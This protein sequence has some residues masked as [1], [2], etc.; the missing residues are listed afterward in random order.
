M[1]KRKTNN[2]ILLEQF[3]QFVFVDRCLLFSLFFRHCVVCPPLIY[4]SDLVS[5]NS[6]F[7]IGRFPETIFNVIMES[8]IHLEYNKGICDLLNRN[9]NETLTNVLVI[10]VII[11]FTHCST[12]CQNLR[13]ILIS[14]YG[15]SI[16]QMS[17]LG[18][19]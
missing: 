13:N 9:C 3:Q 16:F 17:D 4:G 18:R 7:K 14:L 5:S 19:M 12:I 1:K 2:S 10:I 8:G 11:S 6:S 15:V